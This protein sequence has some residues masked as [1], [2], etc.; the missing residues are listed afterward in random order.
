MGV[1][2]L[3]FKIFSPINWQKNWRKNDNDNSKFRFS[4]ATTEQKMDFQEKTPFL[5]QKI[6]GNRQVADHNIGPWIITEYR[7]TARNRGQ[8]RPGWPPCEQSCAAPTVPAGPFPV[9]PLPATG[10]PA[11]SE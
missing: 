10:L 6:G 7:N 2:V 5:S 1:K 11:V 3:I 8:T 9:L 4:M